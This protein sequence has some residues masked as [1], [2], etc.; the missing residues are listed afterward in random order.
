[1]PKGLSAPYLVL[2]ARIP[3]SLRICWRRFCCL[4]RALSS[5]VVVVAVGMSLSPEEATDAAKS[6]DLDDGHGLIEAADR[7]VHV[8]VDDGLNASED[9]ATTKHIAENNFIIF[10]V[11]LC[12]DCYL[13]LNKRYNFTTSVSY[14]S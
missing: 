11:L 4:V 2:K 7:G 6:G 10:F 3:P 9:D 12:T 14:Q 13:L 1:M 5:V 8:W